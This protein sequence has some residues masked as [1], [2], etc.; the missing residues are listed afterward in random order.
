M[1]YF[2]IGQVQLFPSYSINVEEQEKIDR[3]FEL[4][5]KSGVGEILEKQRISSRRTGGRPAYNRYQLFAMILYGFAFSSGTARDLESLC[6]NDLRYIYIMKE[7]QPSY[8]TIINFFNDYI[9][10]NEEIIFKL[11]NKAIL[12]ECGVQLEDVYLDG[13]KI[14]ADANKY[15]FVWKP[16]TFHNRLSDKIRNLLEIIGLQNSLPKTGIIDSK[17]VAE[18]LIEFSEMIERTDESKRKTLIKQ[19]DQLTEYLEKSLEYEE[20]ER[21]CGPDRNSY[22]KTDH[23]ATAMTLK[24]DY[25]SGLGSNMRAAYNTQAA[26]ANGFVVS[27][28]VS[29]SRTDYH[30]L[31]PTIERFYFFNEC[32]P[33]NLCADSGYGILENYEYLKEKNIV[34]Y[35]KYSSWQGNVSGKNPDRYRLQD[36][37]SIVCLNGHIGYQVDLP[38][39]HPKNAR[40]VFYKITGCLKCAF[41]AY[42]KRWQKNKSEN[43][44]IF[45]VCIPFLILKQETERNLLSVKGI[46][47]RV[48]R[49]SQV[50]GSFG[51]LKQNMRYVRFRRT[52]LPKVTAEY[53]LTFLGYNIR[54]LFRHY[55]GKSLPE[56]WTAPKDIQPESFKKPSAKKLS[57]KASKKKQKTGNQIAK[58]SYKNKKK[59]G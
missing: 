31:I 29:Q 54:K 50:E 22:Y 33:K 4:L 57:K 18:K 45:E 32:Y 12:E 38:D 17:I 58:E 11:V 48:N 44:K 25:Y 27:Y 52:T 42:C 59:K 20:K 5:E 15:K 30:E 21:I 43:F 41:S 37:N 1:R 6:K 51:V 39:R 53:M 14:E 10:P 28:H 3:F 7:E 55:S 47:M 34:S 13:T 40:S 56:Y 26:V 36:D 8:R 46:E 2:N 23:D 9:V 19:F 16:T 24:S 35:V 49:S